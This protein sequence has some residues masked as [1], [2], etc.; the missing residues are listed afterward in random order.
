VVRLDGTILDQPG[1]DPITRLIYVPSPGF[2]LPPLPTTPSHAEVQQAATWLQ[3]ELFPDFPFALDAYGRPTVSA[4]KANAMALLLTPILRPAIPGPVPL[5]VIEAPQAGTGKTLLAS[6]IV[7]ATTGHQAAMQA[8]P[9]EEAEWRK[10]LTAILREGA[11]FCVL[12]NVHALW[13]STLAAAL[14]APTWTDR[15]LGST[16]ML[17]LP[18]HT[19][20]L[21]T[22]N[23]IEVGG[24]LPRRC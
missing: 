12:D 6:A 2:V 15:L 7:V 11:P 1:Y 20:F 4:S 16:Q 17:T 8:A 24:D 19:V 22:G 5:G 14:T 9:R 18:Q 21:A 23:N 10:T 13:S 3:T